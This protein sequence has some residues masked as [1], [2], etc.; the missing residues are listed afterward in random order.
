MSY[1]KKD[2]ILNSFRV[3][4]R[5]RPIIENKEAKSSKKLNKD[6]M[7]VIDNQVILFIDLD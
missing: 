4:I 2:G 5:I 6:F 7:T 3:F 1:Q